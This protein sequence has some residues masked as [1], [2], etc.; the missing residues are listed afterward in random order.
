MKQKNLLWKNNG[1]NVWRSQT[2]IFRMEKCIHF[3]NF[4]SKLE[5]LAEIE[6]KI[7]L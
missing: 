6:D 3:C 5:Q 2:D 1:P 4:F 7:A